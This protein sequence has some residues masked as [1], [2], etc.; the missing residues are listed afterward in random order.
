MTEQERQGGWQFPP[1]PDVDCIKLTGLAR[2]TYYKYKRQI[3]EDA[4]MNDWLLCKR[5]RCKSGQK[6]H[7]TFKTRMPC[8]FFC[9]LCRLDNHTV[10]PN[11]YN[12][13]RKISQIGEKRM[14][15]FLM[16]LLSI[17]FVL[18][19]AIV[20]GLIGGYGSPRRALYT[21]TDE[22]MNSAYRFKRGWQFK[23]SLPWLFI[24]IFK[25]S[26]NQNGIFAICSLRMLLVH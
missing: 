10:Q 11:L 12:G 7:G 18:N 25:N 4:E 20:I 6:E 23:N 16:V 3:R 26:A 15:K 21:I 17:A 1:I 14:R 24:A 22:L 19:L 5:S 9:G 8:S 13:G 2:N